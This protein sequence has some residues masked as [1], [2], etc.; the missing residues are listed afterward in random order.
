M[1][2]LWACW[3]AAELD[4]PALPPGDGP[5]QTMNWLS[6]I[7]DG[8]VPGRDFPVFHGLGVLWLH[9]PLYFLGGGGAP[10]IVLTYQGTSAILVVL[11]LAFALRLG[12]GRRFPAVAV[13]LLAAFALAISPWTVSRF[14]LPGH[15][16]IAARAAGGLLVVMLGWW[17]ANRACLRSNVALLAGLLAGWGWFFSN[18]QGPGATLGLW[19]VMAARLRALDGTATPWWRTLPALAG[20]SAVMVA[21]CAAS[22]VALVAAATLG[23]PESML[24]YYF[25]AIPANQ[26]WW[27]GGPPSRFA[28]RWQDL[29]YFPALWVP[30][31]LWLAAGAAVCRGRRMPGGA[32]G[33][34]APLFGG[35][36]AC[37]ALASLPVLGMLLPHYSAG[38]VQGVVLAAAV[39]TG[40]WWAARASR[41]TRRVQDLAWLAAA[42]VAVFSAITLYFIWEW[43]RTHLPGRGCDDAAQLARVVAGAPP[44]PT[45]VWSLYRGL[46]EEA[47]DIQR[48]TQWDY[49]IHA[50]GT[51][52]QRSY[53]DAFLR[54]APAVVRTIRAERF[55]FHGWLWHTRWGFFGPLLQAYRPCAEGELYVDWTR[56]PQPVVWKRQT[57]PVRVTRDPS[58]VWRWSI[59]LPRGQPRGTL[60]EV[61]LVVAQPGAAI[62]DGLRRKL[63]RIVVSHPQGALDGDAFAI[64]PA[65]VAGGRFTWCLL[66]NGSA[67]IDGSLALRG[68]LPAPATEI[69]SIEA[70]ALGVLEEDVVRVLAPGV[71]AQEWHQIREPK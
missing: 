34:L 45:P 62:G 30:C 35:W 9:A 63:A 38:L 3:I 41:E 44:G 57:L 6:R 11:A 1:A 67:A 52:A 18:D 68:P 61:R 69:V 58:G 2:G 10:G 37:G 22:Y 43:R 8:Q 59:D 49:V 53:D 23:H 39:L 15:S 70:D 28:E 25:R 24:D 40:R 12:W 48:P 54:C 64:P 4:H 65:G 20:W 7:G 21:T 5:L 50:L 26:I 47:M 56:R 13:A 29:A 42:A 36:F 17:A 51:D 66:S 19:L 33:A 32:T 71:P 55:R 16:M 60:V 46:A 31:L 27:F 14:F